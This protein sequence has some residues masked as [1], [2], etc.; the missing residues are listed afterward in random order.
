[1]KNWWQMNGI[2][3]KQYYIRHKVWIWLLLV[4]GVLLRLLEGRFMQ[5][6]YAGM[7][8]GVYAQDEQGRE[9]LDLL[10]QEEGIFRFL[11][12]NSEEELRRQVE[13]GSLE[14]GYVLPE[15][16]YRELLSGKFR[17]QIGIY[18]SP[19]SSAHRISYEVVFSH[20][21]QEFSDRILEDYLKESGFDSEHF[22]ALLALKEEYE[23][24]ESTF[25]FRYET[26]GGEPVGEENTLDVLR[27]CIGVLM[28]FMSLLGLGNCKELT[29]IS[30]R[31]PASKGNRVKSMSLHIA[32]LGSIT[33]GAMLIL[34]SGIGQDI[35]QE[36]LGLLVY[37]VVLEI[38]LRLLKVLLPTSRAIYGMIPVLTLGSLLFAP[39]FIRIE[40]YIPAASLIGRLFPV[41]W[42]LE[43]FYI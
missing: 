17:R 13:N 20:L 11:S 32:A 8:I 15:G 12:F 28:F 42:Y 30:S 4:M 23:S 36:I 3:W 40:A 37:W 38:Y 39:V 1:M 25:S 14:C 24:N 35:L 7:M 10:Q 34:L 41:T 19:A 9:L 2:L 33:M 43:A 27:G 16:F 29:G 22:T 6:E 18:Y 26:V 5:Q 21:Y 31:I